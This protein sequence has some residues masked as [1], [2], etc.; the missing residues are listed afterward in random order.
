[1][2][3]E[4]KRLR[5]IRHTDDRPGYTIL[6]EDGTPWRYVKTPEAVV[7]FA[8]RRGLLLAIGELDERA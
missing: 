6:K 1:M 7:A 3:D 8:K 5:A 2:T 4:P